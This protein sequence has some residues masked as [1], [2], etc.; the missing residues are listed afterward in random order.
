MGVR[1]SC[2]DVYGY[3][4]VRG[5]AVQMCM[6]ILVYGVVLCRWNLEDAMHE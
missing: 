3:I 2:V 1:Y 6:G 4:G 5:G